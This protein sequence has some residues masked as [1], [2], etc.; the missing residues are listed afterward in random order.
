[1]KGLKVRTE[2]AN[3]KY[4]LNW[5]QSLGPRNEIAFLPLDVL[6][7]GTLKSASVSHCV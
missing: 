1:M 6:K 7:R 5:F 3:L 2:G 4:E